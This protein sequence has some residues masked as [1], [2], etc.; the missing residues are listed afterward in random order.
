MRTN[1]LL[2]ISAH[3]NT[4]TRQAN[5]QRRIAHAAAYLK[6]IASA[7]VVAFSGC[8]LGAPIAAAMRSESDWSTAANTDTTGGTSCQSQ[9]GKERREGGRTLAGLDLGA[10][11]VLEVHGDVMHEVPAVRVAEDL[12]VQRARL[13]EVDCKSDAA[14]APSASYVPTVTDRRDDARSVISLRSACA[15]PRKTSCSTDSYSLGLYASGTM[16]LW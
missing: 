1:F 7:A 14:Y 13:L 3:A 10:L 2:V 4:T 15:V 12:L 9:A 11:R 6:R 16:L 8:T 5:R